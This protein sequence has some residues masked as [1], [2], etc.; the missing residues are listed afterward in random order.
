MSLPNHENL[1]KI[2]TVVLQNDNITDTWHS[3]EGGGQ[4]IKTF[5]DLVGELVCFLCRAELNCNRIRLSRE[6]ILTEPP[7]HQSSKPS[8][9][10]LLRNQL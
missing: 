6:D 2:K 4:K 3:K 10:P 1:F 9:A 5:R 8:P 7:S